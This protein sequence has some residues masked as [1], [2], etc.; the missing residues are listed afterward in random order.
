MS[1]LEAHD[2]ESQLGRW[3]LLIGRSCCD[4][5]PQ[6][7]AADASIR[8]DDEADVTDGSMQRQLSVSIHMSVMRLQLQRDRRESHQTS[9]NVALYLIHS[10][11]HMDV[12][13]R[14]DLK[15]Q[16]RRIVLLVYLHVQGTKE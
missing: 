13:L 1:T 6:P 8:A 16:S 9:S 4:L 12:K 2:E 15:S 3:C 7:K 10:I 14:S 11:N 5:T